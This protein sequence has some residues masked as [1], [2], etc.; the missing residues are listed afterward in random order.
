MQ[1]SKCGAAYIFELGGTLIRYE[2]KAFHNAISLFHKETM[3]LLMAQYKRLNHW[4]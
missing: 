1:F 4:R 2:I 3:A